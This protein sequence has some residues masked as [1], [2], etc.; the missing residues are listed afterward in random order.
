MNF[1]LILIVSLV[2]MALFFGEAECFRKR[3]RRLGR[4][5]RRIAKAVQKVAPVVG[6]VRA[7]G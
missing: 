2:L 7:I 3:L 4:A 5:G 1:K 6:A